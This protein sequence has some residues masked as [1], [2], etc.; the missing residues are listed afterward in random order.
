[1]EKI[2]EKGKWHTM[3]NSAK[4]LL[5]SSFADQLKVKEASSRCFQPAL[6]SCV[7][8]SVTINP[9]PSD[10]SH[11]GIECSDTVTL[12]SKEPISAVNMSSNGLILPAPEQVLDGADS[13]AN[14]SLALRPGDRKRTLMR[15][16]AAVEELKS[17]LRLSRPG[18]ETFEFPE[19]DIIPESNESL[20]LLQEAIEE[21]L[22][23]SHDLQ[24]K[25]IWQK[26]KI[27]VERLFVGLSPFAKNFLT[28]ARGASQSVFTD[29]TSKDADRH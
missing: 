27:L 16:I 18:W 11:V 4:K 7:T 28:I 12:L 20:T 21:K 22:N 2:S 14:S 19:F 8:P 13:V 3:T 24:D 17:A 25:T 26:G 1:M 6:Q 29:I 5:R 23:T 15:Y 9:Q 10:P